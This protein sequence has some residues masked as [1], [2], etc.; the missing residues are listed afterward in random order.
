MAPG[1]SRRHC[2]AAISSAWLQM[3]A[4]A[5]AQPQAASARVVS[6]ASRPALLRFTFSRKQDDPRT[7]W[8]IK[9]Y[10]EVLDTL[11][12]G[13]A[14]VD[15]PP[16][17]GLILVNTGEADGEL[18]RTWGYGSLHDS[19]IR[20]PTPNNDVEFV[21]YVL[22]DRIAAGF[23]GWPAIRDQRWH[24]EYRRGVDEAASLLHHQL[25]PTLVSAVGNIES[26]LRRLQLRRTDLYLDVGEAVEDFLAFGDGRERVLPGP[27]IRR[28][29][30]VQTTTGHAYLHRRHA[31]LVPDISDT[32]LTLKKRGL[33]ARYREDAMRQYLQ[34]RQRRME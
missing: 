20:V 3:P 8:L 17:R 16:A 18:G 6:P 28:L 4:P 7:Q 27:V 1:I 21:A 11:G 26:G 33:V 15:A 24:C 23:P 10:T 12:I 32:L 9:V 29:Q 2:I 34:S 31:S 25:D 22:E 5:L 13:F 14:F 19:L 30:A